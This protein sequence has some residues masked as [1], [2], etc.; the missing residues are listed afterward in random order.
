MLSRIL[1]LILL[2]TLIGFG[3]PV[4]G[5]S[6]Q[7]ADNGIRYTL[8]FPEGGLAQ[9]MA[10]RPDRVPLVSPHRGGPMPGFPENAIETLDNSLRY[11]PS[12]LEVDVMQLKDGT[13]ILMHDYT[14]DRTTTGTGEVKDS[15]WDTVS[16]LFL[17]DN[18]GELTTY[19][20]PTLDEALTW[21]KGRAI[22]NLDIKR[23]VPAAAVVEKVQAHKAQDSVMLITYNLD[24]AKT[25]HALAPN[26]MLN[27][28]M[29]DM[30][31]LKA[32]KAS[33]IAPNR[34]V[35]W[36]G[37]QLRDKAFY[38]AVHAEGWRVAMG[39]LGFDERGIDRQIAASG[40][41]ARYREIYG[42]G[43]DLISTDRHW[44]VQ[45]Q[46]FNPNLVYFQFQTGFIQ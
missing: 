1:S 27:V 13:L 16:K 40:N 32:V 6:D 24:Q 21:A 31:G 23:G 45:A 30:D 14:L 8:N 43:V 25:F 36:T 3:S 19:R 34:I 39:T 17:K 28:S 11:G 42:M 29:R 33:G 12:I 9:L 35:A 20:V 5:Q 22:L 44:A 10:W 41:E 2:T 7:P 15:D 26:L 46:V 37:L 4:T 38:D 18:D